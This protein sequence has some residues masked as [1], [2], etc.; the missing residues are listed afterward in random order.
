MASITIRNLTDDD[1]QALRE[2][3]ARHGRSMEAEARSILREALRG[4]EDRPRR[5]LAEEIRALFGP[6]GGVDLPEI[7]REPVRDPPKFE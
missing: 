1:K 5:N 7:P 6:L 2:Q 3:A 4:K